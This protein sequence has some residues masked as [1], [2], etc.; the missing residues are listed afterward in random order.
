MANTLRISIVI[1]F[2]DETTNLAPL[3]KEI[4]KYT[5]DLN[6]KFELIFVDDGSQDNS[7]KVIEKLKRKDKRIK[8]LRFS[9][10]FGK[11]AATSAGLH[12]AT[13]DAVIIMDSDLQHPP[14]LIPK[15]IKKWESGKEVIIGIKTYWQENID[16]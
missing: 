7:A 9:R 12:S 11:E 2:H 13:G 3:Y 10:N 6:Y 8:L 5:K 14:Q 1:P 16:I 4:S 15:F